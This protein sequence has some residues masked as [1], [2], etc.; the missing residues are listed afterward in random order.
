[1]AT[2]GRVIH[3]IRHFAPNPENTILFSGFQVGGTP[4]D[5]MIRDERE[6]KMFGQMIPIREIVQIENISVDAESTE[7][8]N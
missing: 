7:M 1:M 3:H 2:G 8:L 4:G 5:R 6:I